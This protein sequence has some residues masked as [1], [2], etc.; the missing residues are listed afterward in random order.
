MDNHL[1]EMASAVE[2][3]N[4][5]ENLNGL[6]FSDGIEFNA[7]G[8]YVSFRDYAALQAE[9]ARLRDALGFY[10]NSDNWEVDDCLSCDAGDDMGDIARAAFCQEG[11]P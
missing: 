1:T 6:G 9:N 7:Q 3:Y 5:T 8:D 4:V 10:A 11:K 2:R